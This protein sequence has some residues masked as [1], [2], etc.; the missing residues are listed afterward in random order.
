[1]KNLLIIPLLSLALL[2]GSCSTGKITYERH[3]NWVIRQND[4]PRYFAD[5]DVLY[6][7]PGAFTTNTTPVVPW[8][9]QSM[10]AETRE[11]SLYQTTKNFGNRARVFCPFIPMLQH[12]DF[13]RLVNSKPV[14]YKE[15][16][17]W[18]SIKHTIEA[19][20]YYFKHFHSNGRPYILF[21]QGQGALVLYEVL[22]EMKQ[23]SPEDGFVAAYL[24][25]LPPKMREDILLDFEG[26][27][28]RPAESDFDIS[29]IITWYPVLNFAPVPE[30]ALKNAYQMNPVNW[31]TDSTPAPSDANIR[32]IFYNCLASGIKKLHQV[33][34]PC[35]AVIDPNIGCLRFTPDFTNPELWS[36][37]H[38]DDNQFHADKHSLFLGNIAENAFTRAKEY[39]FKY[40][41][42]KTD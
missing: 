6:L 33:N 17:L 15:S 16:P 29:V 3:D 42:R 18:P 19:F 23:I 39:K 7:Y 12:E 35:S 1:M 8:S 13:L 34:N 32:A 27:D 25:G 22:R 28:I 10:F 5:F 21:G 11:F 40:N 4:V 14:S 20:D 41:W 24:S 38:F 26:R 2:L 9:E 31:K 30:C 37:L 36:V